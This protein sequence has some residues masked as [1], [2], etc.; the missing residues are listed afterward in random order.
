MLNVTYPVWCTVNDIP[1]QYP[2]LSQ[3][4]SCDVCVVGGGITGALCALRLARSGMDTVLITAHQLASDGTAQTMPLCEYDMGVSLLELEQSGHSACFPAVLEHGRRALDELEQLAACLDGF[5]YERTD[6]VLFAQAPEELDLLAR[7]FEARADAGCDVSWLDGRTAR[8]IFRFSPA[9]AIIG[10]GLAARLDPFLLAHACCTAAHKLGARIYENTAAVCID[11]GRTLIVDTSTRRTICCK[12]AVIASGVHTLGTEGVTLR[13][14][15]GFISVGEPGAAGPHPSRSVMRTLSQPTVTFA[16][17]PDSRPCAGGLCTGVVDEHGFMG[18]LRLH[19]LCNR[20]FE[21]LAASGRE[22]Y[23]IPES[24]FPYSCAAGFL[25]SPDRLPVVCR[26]S[27]HPECI[28]AVSPSA[29]GIAHALS[30][31]RIAHKLCTEI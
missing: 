19:R 30:A 21:E 22:L 8:E 16:I 11:K 18:S 12:Q 15:T 20:R 23:D 26:H 10:K 17:S 4:E 5:G 9:G 31:A 29:N 7:E 2:W 28:C 3:D 6:S 1:A 24:P 25:Q 27:E 14:K 13:K